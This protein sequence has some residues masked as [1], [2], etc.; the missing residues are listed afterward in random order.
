M[1]YFKDAKIK[2]KIKRV[3]GLPPLI[4][5]DI[6]IYECMYVLCMHEQPCHFIAVFIS[7]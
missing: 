3:G 2:K 7:S 4:K 1:K 5:K 6:Y